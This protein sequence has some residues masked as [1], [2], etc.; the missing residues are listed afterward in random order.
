ME[1]NED[2]MGDN[3]NNIIFGRAVSWEQYGTILSPRYST[4]PF[5]IPKYAISYPTFYWGF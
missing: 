3:T 2:I 1:F 5:H 4:A